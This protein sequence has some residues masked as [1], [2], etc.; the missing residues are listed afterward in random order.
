MHLRDAG[1]RRGADSRRP[2]RRRRPR[3]KGACGRTNRARRRGQAVGGEELRDHRAHSTRAGGQ[4]RA[5]RVRDARGAARQVRAQGRDP[6]AGK[7]PD[8]Y[9]VQRRCAAADSAAHAAAAESRD[10]G[11]A[12]RGVREHAQDAARDGQTGFRAPDARHVRDVVQGVPA[13]VQVR[14]SG[15]GAAGTRGR[16]RG[17]RRR[18][19]HGPLLRA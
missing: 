17:H 5:D 10:A 2:A 18:Q 14:R 12:S 9:R 8:H 4:P 19:L 11:A 3:G 1:R 6:G 13:H 7:R 16:A 15:R